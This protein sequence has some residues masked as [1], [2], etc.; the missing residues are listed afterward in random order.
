M[1]AV[2][3]EEAKSRDKVSIGGDDC[4]PLRSEEQS[5]EGKPMMQDTEV[6]WLE[7]HPY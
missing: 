5:P 2:A 1:L 7:P 6:G 4:L 3:E